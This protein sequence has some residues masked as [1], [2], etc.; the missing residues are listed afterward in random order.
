MHKNFCLPSSS[1][2]IGFAFL[3][4]EAPVLNTKEQFVTTPLQHYPSTGTPSVSLTTVLD[5]LGP[6]SSL[7]K[8]LASS[9][10]SLVTMKNAGTLW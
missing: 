8:L 2:N 7:Q 4:G 1:F 3:L 5:Y 6:S 9:M 10:T